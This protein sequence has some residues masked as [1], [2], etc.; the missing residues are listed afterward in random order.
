MFQLNTLKLFK[1]YK[2]NVLQRPLLI[3]QKN[4]FM[5][6]LHFF[7]GQQNLIKPTQFTSKFYF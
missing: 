1:K 3:L 6:L 7:L 2:H 4:N 5:F